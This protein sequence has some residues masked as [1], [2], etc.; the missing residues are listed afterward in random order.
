MKKLIILLFAFG[1]FVGCGK[2]AHKVDPMY[3]GTWQGNDNKYS[4][5]LVVRNG[6]RGEWSKR[7][8]GTLMG[9]S[10]TTANGHVRVLGGNLRIGLKKLSLDQEPQ[11]IGPNFTLKLDGVTYYR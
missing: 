1:L 7:E 11:Q 2:K 10:V 8:I 4:Y 3:V 9:G 5:A 6:E